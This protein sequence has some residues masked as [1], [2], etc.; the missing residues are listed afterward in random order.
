MFD[1]NKACH[2][3][4]RDTWSSSLYHC[5]ALQDLN[6]LTFFIL[7]TFE[8]LGVRKFHN[9]TGLHWDSESD[10]FYAP[11]VMKVIRTIYCDVWILFREY[12]WQ[13]SV[14]EWQCFGK[15]IIIN[16]YVLK[17]ESFLITG[18][19]MISCA[20]L[21]VPGL[22]YLVSYHVETRSSIKSYKTVSRASGGHG[23]KRWPERLWPW[24]DCR[25]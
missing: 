2:C 15:I 22:F 13:Y 19:F 5:I 25:S 7:L 3:W 18:V 9:Y 14:L 8:Y 1:V 4:S 11:V 17:L 21:G 16:Y 20:S 23:E 10:T 12:F 6:K 24:P